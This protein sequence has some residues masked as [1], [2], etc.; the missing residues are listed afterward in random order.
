MMV[1]FKVPWERYGIISYLAREMERFDVQFGKT[2]L[3][4]IIYILQETYD[5]RIGYSYILYNYGPF[6]AGL[7]NDLDYVAAL[8]GVK[9]SWVNT[10]GYNIK[11]D[12]DADAFINKGKFFIDPNKEK[13]EEALKVFGTMTAK[14][15][16]L[17]ATIIYFVKEYSEEDKDCIPSEIHQLKPYFDEE[18]IRK[19]FVEL[20]CKGIA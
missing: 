12:I 18:Q 7:A 14:E 15:L 10:G 19:A 13:I 9:V 17:N 6:S 8:K 4:K 20:K 1:D 2:S 16:E 3:Q 11:P 5:V